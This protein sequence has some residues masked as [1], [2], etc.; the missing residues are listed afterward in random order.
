MSLDKKE[1]GGG[2]PA[3]ETRKA[4]Y[5]PPKLDRHQK[6]LVDI[7]VYTLPTVTVTGL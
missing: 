7:T 5:V 4:A 1:D 6:K 3:P 2:I